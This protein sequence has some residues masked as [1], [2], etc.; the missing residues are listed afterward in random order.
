MGT[1]S[2]QALLGISADYHDA[3][4][5]LIVDGVVVAA[6]E[7]ERF[8]RTKHDPSI[9]RN[10]IA[11]CLE[12]AGIEPDGLAG[13]A[14][15]DKPFTT[16][17]R[18]L[19]TAA[20][21][22]PKGFPALATAVGQWSKSKL[23]VGYR[24]ERTLRSLGYQMPALTYAEHHQ[25]HAASAFYPSPFERA[26]I[27]T[28]D[29][30]GEWA[31]STIAW[32]AGHRIE[33]RKEM[34]FPDSLG[35]L[36]SAF[37][38]FCGF[39]VNDGEYKLMG[40]APYGEP[41]YASVLR[42]R[43]VHIADD[44]SIRIDQRWFAYRAGRSMTRSRLAELLD[45]PAREPEGPLTQREAD[46]AR[47]V[48]ELIEE[49]VLKMARHAH[50]LTGERS[51]CLSGGVALNCV[52]NTK[53]LEDGPFDEIWVQPA[54]G[55]DGSALGCA[56]WTWHQIQDN[57]RTPQVP[58]GMAGASLGPAFDHGEI[59]S[60]LTD[61]EV[62]FTEQTDTAALVGEVADALASGAI[63]GWFQGRMEFGPR[64]LGHRS[65]LADPRD[66]S[67]VQRLNQAVKRREGFRPFAPSVL[68]EEAST[69]FDLP[70]ASPYMLL[71]PK[72]AAAQLREP[73][74]LPDGATFTERLAA[75]RSTIPACTHVDHSARVQTVDAQTDPL[76]H[77]L[78]T[79]FAERTGCPVLVNTSFNRR[80]EPIVRTP[81]DALRCFADTDMDLLVLEGCI[82]RKA[83]LAE[84][85]EASAEPL[86]VAAP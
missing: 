73:E 23:W 85:G 56:L 33:V 82:V 37:T 75:T 25:S 67:M 31:T 53:I 81:A 7:E 62:D 79:A 10:A 68:A 47:S 83:D 50:E 41:R 2:G 12:E 61:A 40:L 42:D 27:L 54:A 11:W 17:E 4:A 58:D 30:I 57:P 46:I 6:A 59:A 74:A 64:A 80:D 69:W 16:Y 13:V 84:A 86:V 55:D 15:Y 32:G 60:W 19:V 22:G 44:G 77:A 43:V 76:F 52:A 14:F 18:I 63:V 34:R 72:V 51:A 78:L 1:S 21:V 8:T 26:A 35:L 38:A 71:T 29:G 36:Y 3:A 70:V 24:I 28:F 66:A 45:G 48:Q 9:P 49:A 20:Q 5:A 65:I 39:A